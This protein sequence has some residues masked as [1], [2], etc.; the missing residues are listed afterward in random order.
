MIAI[1]VKDRNENPVV[2]ERFGRCDLFYIID[3]KGNHKFIK[4][5][6]KNLTSGAGGKAVSILADEGVTKI[7]S[8]HIGP[9]AMDVIKIIN[10]DIYD[11]GDNKTVKEALLSLQANKLNIVPTKS[12]GLKRV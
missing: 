1:P 7:I 11:I 3:N 5:S 2:D 6:A 8:P 12:S 9:K 10:M 4:N